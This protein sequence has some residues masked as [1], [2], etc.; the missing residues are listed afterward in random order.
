MNVNPTMPRYARPSLSTA[1]VTDACAMMCVVCAPTGFQKSQD[2][3]GRYL[4]GIAVTT[5]RGAG[6][7][8]VWSY[9]VGISDTEHRA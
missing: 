1:M 8:H 2:I 5:D 7:E 3:N 6:R 4:D 9:G